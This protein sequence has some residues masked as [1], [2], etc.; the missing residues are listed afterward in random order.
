MKSIFFGAA[1]VLSALPANAD[2]FYQSEVGNWMVFGEDPASELNPACVIS[3]EWQDGSEFQLIFDL[4][5]RE[6]F[7]WFRNLE[8]DIIDPEGFYSLNMVAVGR[9]NNVVSGVLDYYLLNK[10]TIDIPDIEPGT[11][12][13]AFARMNELRFVMPGNI[14]NAYLDLDGS[15]AATMEFFDCINLGD[16]MEFGEGDLGMPL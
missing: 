3:Y 4:Y 2:Y 13:D 14:Q 1:L 12:L 5:E 6:L 8:W 7:I 11:F 15:R 9:N 16:T 10:N